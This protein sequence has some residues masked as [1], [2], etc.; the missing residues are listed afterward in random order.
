MGNDSIGA[1]GL[2]SSLGVI[3]V[4]FLLGDVKVQLPVEAGIPDL[5]EG[6]EVGRDCVVSP[7]DLIA[8]G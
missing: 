6:V 7:E 2:V 5:D 1:A 8:L 3:A 4:Q